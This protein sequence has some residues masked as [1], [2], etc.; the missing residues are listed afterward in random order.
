MPIRM[1]LLCRQYR[2]TPSELG[3]ARAARCLH[4][5]NELKIRWRLEP[6]ALR[7]SVLEHVHLGDDVSR[8][9][10]CKVGIRRESLHGMAWRFAEPA[11]VVETR[12]RRGNSFMKI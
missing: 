4:G 11:G 8:R 7:A 3:V 9:N 12:V 5:H 2:F 10:M 1:M 6:L